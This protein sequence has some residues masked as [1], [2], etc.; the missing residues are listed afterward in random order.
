MLSLTAIISLSAVLYG[1]YR[2]LKLEKQTTEVLSAV[3]AD[4]TIELMVARKTIDEA[5]DSLERINGDMD[6]LQ[7]IVD[8]IERKY[9]TKEE[10]KVKKTTK[11]QVKKAVKKVT[12]K[13]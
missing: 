11:K 12:K 6:D 2:D 10:P 9:C 3:M 5:M 1:Y 8:E 4:R 13:A 7:E